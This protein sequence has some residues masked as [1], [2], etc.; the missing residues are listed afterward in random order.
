MFRRSSAL[1]RGDLRSKG[2]GKSSIQF[3]GRDETVE[4][5]IRT[6]ISV[7]QFSICG[8]EADM[9]EELAWE[10]SK[11]SEGIGR[12][13][14]PNDSETMVMPTELS[15]TIKPL[16]PM[17]EYRETCCSIMSKSSPIFQF[18]LN[19]PTCAPMQVSRIL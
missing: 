19:F 2:K 18:I 13:V 4:V 10:I 15:T 17:R 1:E 6:T 16:R 14:A 9:C 7:N 5:V 12:P 11:C 3:N 8:A